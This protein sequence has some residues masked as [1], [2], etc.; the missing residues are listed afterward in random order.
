MLDGTVKTWEMVSWDNWTH[1]IVC[2]DYK[3]II[4]LLHLVWQTNVFFVTSLC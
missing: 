4:L 3:N 1:T 2:V